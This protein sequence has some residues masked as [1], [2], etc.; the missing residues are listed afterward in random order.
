VDVVEDASGGCVVA[1]WDDRGGLTRSY[2]QRVDG[3][4]SV[5][6]TAD[7]L[8]LGTGTGVQLIQDLCWSDDGAIAVW[9]DGRGSSWD[10]YGQKIDA[11]GTRLWSSPLGQLLCGASDTQGGAT[12]NPDG[13][14]GAYVLWQ[15]ARSRPFDEIYAQHVTDAGAIDWT[16]DGVVPAMVSLVSASYL[17]GAAKLEWLV[18]PGASVVVERSA[19]G[20]A[21]SAVASLVADGE[22]RVRYEDAGV[23]PGTRYGWRL[24]LGDATR[25][26]EAWLTVPSAL[27]FAL[28]GARPNPAVSGMTV[29]FTLPQRAD[30]RLEIMDVQGRRVWGR[31]VGAL[32]IGRHRVELGTSSLAPGVYVLRLTQGTQSATARVAVLR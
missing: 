30:A 22:G 31:G 1:W 10:L 18:G 21:W 15:D 26:G 27:A 13:L 5:A 7:G 17:D 16:T 14:G 28:E 3:T 6:W 24:L 23:E 8:P 4:A 9:M 11:G 12:V 25:G 32:G 2:A 20:V 19:D 29:A